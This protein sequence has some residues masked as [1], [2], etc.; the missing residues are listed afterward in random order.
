MFE[1]RC[2]S[3]DSLSPSPPLRSDGGMWCE[4]CGHAREQ[5]TTSNQTA[6]ESPLNPPAAGGDAASAGDGGKA[7]PGS[8]DGGKRQANPSVGRSSD[9]GGGREVGV[10]E[11]VSSLEKALEEAKRSKNTQEKDAGEMI[12]I[13]ERD[14]ATFQ[15]EICQ[16]SGDKKNLESEVETLRSSLIEA[17]EAK[18]KYRDAYEQLSSAGP[19]PAPPTP[20]SVAHKA[21]KGK[22]LNAT[23]SPARAPAAP[24]RQ[25]QEPHK[26]QQQISAVFACIVGTVFLTWAIYATGHLCPATE[27]PTC[28]P[29]SRK[30]DC[31]A[32]ESL[33]SA[34]QGREV[35]LK[36]KL[37]D[38][39]GARSACIASRDAC[40]ATRSAS[41]T[42]DAEARREAS[43]C[44]EQMREAEERAEKQ[45]KGWVLC[46]A[47]LG[48]AKDGL[49]ELKAREHSCREQ[50]IRAET[51]IRRQQ[52]PAQVHKPR[53]V[54]S[55][56]SSAS[57][58]SHHHLQQIEVWAKFM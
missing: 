26:V 27:C 51:Q 6:P 14:L 7:G 37:A 17:S 33:V 28:V 20:P 5:P 32:A 4:A 23:P 21:I 40:E 15:A 8:E 31:A 53:T 29:T 49:T 19:E 46:E 11:K 22:P 56:T 25:Q 48:E 24:Q 36:R 38:V 12:A 30:G 58:A 1:Y 10:S 47:K 3:C 18:T 45:S 43:S 57:A 50:K 42:L 44:A 39:E 52:R 41:E 54:G 9:V 34:C 35:A 2:P 55:S 16:L 13:L